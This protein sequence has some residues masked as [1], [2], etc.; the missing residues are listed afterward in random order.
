[1]KPI[2]DPRVALLNDDTGDTLDGHQWK[3][4]M[5]EDFLLMGGAYSYI[6]RAR[7]TAKS[8]H[9]VENSLVGVLKNA[10][11]IDKKYQI[12]VNGALYRDFQFVKLLRK[13][14]DGA[15]G[16]G[17]IRENNVAL[18]VAYNSMIFHESMVKTEAQ[19]KGSL[20][21]K[22]DFRLRLSLNLKMLGL[23]FTQIITNR[24]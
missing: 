7:N 4:S 8:L 2:A 14:K 21:P 19:R 15:T 6:K 3:R 17:I 11:P 24:M 12:Q 22:I 13:S 20:R 1:M 9:F 23:I 10:D 16:C 5:C 18:S